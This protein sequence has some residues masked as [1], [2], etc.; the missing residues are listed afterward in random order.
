MRVTE[1]LSNPGLWGGVAALAHVL[2]GVS[3]LLAAA[4]SPARNGL[5]LVAAAGTAWGVM[6]V[7]GEPGGLATHLPPALLVAEWLLLSSWYLYLIRL[8]RGPYRRSMPAI[9]RRFLHLAWLAALGMSALAFSSGVEVGAEWQAAGH[10][11]LLAMAL[12]N[13][14]LAAQ[15]GRD[16]PLENHGA[17]RLLVAAAAV[18]SGAQVLVH[19]A[20]VL[21]LASW[22][23]MATPSA[24]SQAVAAMIVVLALRL[25]PQWSLAIFVSPDARSYAPRCLSAA[26]FLLSVMA[27]AP[28]VHAMPGPYGDLLAVVLL[29]VI[30]IPLALLMY[31]MRINAR[32]RVFVNKHFLPFRYD[33]REE[34]LR[35]IDTLVAGESESPL[36]ERAIRALAQIVGS[37]AG[38]LWM[39]Q[40]DEGPF[41]VTAAWNTRLWSDAQ[42]PAD[43]RALC[44]ML[45]RQWIIDTAELRRRPALYAGLQRPAWLA[46]FPEG[47]LLVPLISTDRLTGFIV[48]LQANSAFRLTFEEIDLLRTSGRQVAA[49]LAQYH[50]DQKLTEVR[51]FEAFNRLTAFVMHDLKNLISQQSL[52]VRNAARHKQNPAFFEDAIATID[53]SVTRMNKLMR[54]LQGGEAAGIAQRL[55]PALAVREAVARCQG[56]RPLPQLVD[57]AGESQVYI[58]RDRFVA[59]ITHLI[60]NAQDATSAGGTVIIRVDVDDGAVLITIEDDGCGMDEA[61]IRTR[62][63]RPFDTTK[64]SKGMGIGAYQARTFVADAGG[65]LRVESTP[66]KGTRV[67]IS[68]PVVP[69][70]EESVVPGQGG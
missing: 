59:V 56:Q 37:P 67:I 33:Y 55:R 58:D 28:V 39:R 41:T 18:A 13:F 68:L 51:Q 25:R 60:G 57:E 10:F 1:G 65:S 63:F 70:T 8:L 19:T 29:A 26:L 11:G 7:R 22:P 50:A 27:V 9:V 2:L 64:G 5:L 46:S 62:L 30:G 48:L 52:V 42:V 43:D 15:L 69:A 6:V 36:P 24:L 54:Q 47:L 32:L 14:A 12:V 21:G 17:L 53:N 45:D 40:H 23:V 38:L 61:F 4:G 44:F 35:L 66:G 31:S 34:W 3:A 20:A 16:A 49:F